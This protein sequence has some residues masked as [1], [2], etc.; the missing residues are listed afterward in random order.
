MKACVFQLQYSNDLSYSDKFFDERIK[1]LDECTKDCDIIV[2]PEYSDVPCA[3]TT[4][5]ELMHYHNKYIDTL[6]TK[7][8]ETAVRCEAIV[9][10]NALCEVDGKMRNTTYAFDKNGML[11]GKYYKTHIPPGEKSLGVDYEY[12]QKT[13]NTYVLEID[14]VRY[15][16]LTCY[17]FYFYEAF[18]Q[19]A[20]NNVDVIIGCS[21]QRS[22]SHDALEIMCRFL[23]YNTN[24]YVLRSSV[25]F[26]ENATVCGASMIV[27]PEGKVLA[28][29]KGK[30]GKCYAEIDP[31]K[32]YYKA[33][34]FGRGLAAHHEYIEE[35]RNP[36]QYRPQ[37]V[38][39]AKMTIASHTQDSVRIADSIQ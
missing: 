6:L 18:P 17:D 20:R 7:C 23:A 35:G 21:L 12:T 34:G 19:L 1:M 25:S 32:K 11:A 13:D 33:A 14:G 27:T 39:S 30:Y 38:E 15:G 4:A 31:H 10:V 22:D 9:F 8:A 37:A 36:W 28:N 26:D 16:F 29:M 24:A 3:V 5:D 2:M